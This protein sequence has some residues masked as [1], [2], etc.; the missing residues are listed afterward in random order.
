MER[1]DYKMIKQEQLLFGKDD[2]DCFRACVASILEMPIEELPTYN[3]ESWLLSWNN[4][5]EKYGLYLQYKTYGKG[6]FAG[7][8]W[9]A[10]VPSLNL[11]EGVKHVVVMHKDKLVHDP[12]PHKKYKRLDK[13]K[14]TEAFWFAAT[15]PAKLEKG[16][17]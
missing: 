8:Y 12:S 5:L 2:G 16:K 17:E 4:W 13:S 9:I 3:S 1:E 7:G 15:D 14:I 10:S 6:N 11:G